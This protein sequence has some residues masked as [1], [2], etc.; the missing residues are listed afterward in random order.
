MV[1]T[2]RSQVIRPWAGTLGFPLLVRSG[3]GEQVFW[4]LS[5]GGNFGLSCTRSVCSSSSGT[6]V[7]IP[8]KH[9][10]KNSFKARTTNRLLN[11]PKP[12]KN[13]HQRL[14]SEREKKRKE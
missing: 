12:T 3:L 2:V 8:V 1:S 11:R 7:S 4:C 10:A 14:V 9:A 5:R 6:V 13:G